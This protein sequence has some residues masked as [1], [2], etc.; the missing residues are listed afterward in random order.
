MSTIYDAQSEEM[1]IHHHACMFFPSA[2]HNARLQ[3]LQQS[4]I[5]LPTLRLGIMRDMR[6]GQ[7]GILQLYVIHGIPYGTS[8]LA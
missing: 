4:I 3:S 7:S 1:Q 2:T 8:E 5:L 6:Y